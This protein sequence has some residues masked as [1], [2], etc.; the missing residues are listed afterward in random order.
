[1]NKEID[2]KCFDNLLKI[3][4]V[5]EKKQLYLISDVLMVI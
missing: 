5:L 2:T 4:P 1:M 3:T